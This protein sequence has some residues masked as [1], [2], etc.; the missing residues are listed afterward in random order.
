MVN[1]ERV[2][3]LTPAEF[4]EMDKA[5]KLEAAERLRPKVVARSGGFTFTSAPKPVDAPI[6]K[7]D[8]GR[9]AYT[10]WCELVE[11]TK[12]FD[13]CTTSEAITRALKTEVGASLWE[14]S[15]LAKAPDVI[16][17]LDGNFPAPTQPQA[18]SRAQY[19]VGNHGS[20]SNR[21]AVDPHNTTRNIV[22]PDS[23][24]SRLR[25]H[26]SDL[27]AQ[28]GAHGP[29]ETRAVAPDAKETKALAADYVRQ[30]KEL[31]GRGMTAS[32]AHSKLMRDAPNQF[33]AWKASGTPP[34]SATHYAAAGR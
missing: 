13:R 29:Q 18:A 34:L 33:R 5:Q 2:Q 7:A 15:K 19:S 31:V 23:N 3:T 26:H 25:G 4:A 27:V 8:I 17:K 28:G 6:T 20:S 1:G 22:D 11:M 32:A 30:H 24:L 16:A 14:M 12:H 10:S 21:S 9:R